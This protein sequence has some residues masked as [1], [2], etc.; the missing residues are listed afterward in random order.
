MVYKDVNRHIEKTAGL[1]G[2]KQP[3]LMT[4]GLILRS[5]RAGFEKP[6]S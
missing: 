3:F 4:K 5:K 6:P 2:Q 1:T